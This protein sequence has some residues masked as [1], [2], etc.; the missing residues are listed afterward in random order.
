MVSKLYGEAI[1]QHA[2]RSVH[3]HPAAQ[4]LR[5]ADGSRHTSSRSCSS[6]RIA[7][8]RAAA[9][10]LLRRPPANVLLHRRRRRDHPCARS[11]RPPAPARRSTSAA[12]GPEVSIGQLARL[13]HRHRRQ[14]PERPRACPRRR[15]SP[16][17]RCPDMA[18]TDAPHRLTARVGLDEGLRRTYEW[19]RLGSSTAGR[20][21]CGERRGALPG[22]LPPGARIR[23]RRRAVALPGARAPDRVAG[24]AGSRSSAR[25]TN[26]SRSASS[27]PTCSSATPEP[28]WLTE[29][30]LPRLPLA[31]RDVAEF[32]DGGSRAVPALFGD[33]RA[34]G[35]GGRGR[36]AADARRLRK[37]V[38][39]A[40]ALRGAGR[41]MRA[42]ST[43]A[44]RFGQPRRLARASRS[45]RS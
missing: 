8:P 33:R 4:R 23:R 43:A 28:D 29:R 17:R 24:L 6:A 36:P 5:P 41:P 38:P 40:H 9:R 11:T 7:A 3:D 26:C 15:G 32:P 42:T 2:G 31:W 34:A 19:Y 10:G 37:R 35:R 21:T 27:C 20:S 14:A 25:R 45:A 39:H 18:K 1:C 13:G 16:P 30:A 44:S 12:P 22:D